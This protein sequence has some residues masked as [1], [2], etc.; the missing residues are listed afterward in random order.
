MEPIEE[1]IVFKVDFKKSL[2]QRLPL[3]Q[4]RKRNY[5]GDEIIAERPDEDELDIEPKQKV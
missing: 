1:E 2:L 3:A 4:Q 5:I